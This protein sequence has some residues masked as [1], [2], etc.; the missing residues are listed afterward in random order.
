MKPSTPQV[1]QLPFGVSIGRQERG[2]SGVGFA[3]Y[4]LRDDLSIPVR[5]HIHLT[6]HVCFVFDEGYIT[7]TR[8][9]D[10]YCRRGVALY[11]PPGTIHTDH[12]QRHGGL[13][14]TD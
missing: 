10:G 7:N 5:E 9:V 6:A 3:V 8:D 14:D 12:Y 11:H 4:E 13:P 2:V 1:P